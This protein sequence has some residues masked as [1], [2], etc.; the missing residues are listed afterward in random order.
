MVAAV[1]CLG[2]SFVGFFFSLPG[3]G[4]RRVFSAIYS[5]G[6]LLLLHVSED[7][8]AQTGWARDLLL[9]A[10]PLAVVF[11]G[12]T[13]WAIIME[14]S[15]NE[16][17]R[18][19]A[20]LRGKHT[21]ICGLG[22]A[23]QHLVR[24]FRRVGENVVVIDPAQDDAIAASVRRCGVALIRGSATDPRLLD[25]ARIRTADYLFAASEDDGTNIGVALRVIDA[26]QRKPGKRD[27]RLNA[28][29]HIADPQLRASLR[30]Q[31]AFR[32]A[33]NKLRINMFNVFDTMARSLLSLHPLDYKSI[34]PNDEWTVQIVIVGFGLM[35]E[36]ILA[37]AAMVGHYA[38]LRRLKAVV[39]DQN[40]NRKR[41]MFRVRYPQFDQVADVEFLESDVE[42]PETLDRI[43]ALCADPKTISTVLITF[44]QATRGLSV[45]ASLADKLRG[46]VPIRLRVSDKSGLFALAGTD[47]AAAILPRNVTVFGSVDEACRKEN[48]GGG[49]LDK[50]ARAM[51]ADYV[52]RQLKTN[53][54]QAKEGS[55]SDWDELADDLIDS[56][57]QQADHI[58][59][60]LRAVG[61]HVA[62]KGAPGELGPPVETFRDDEVDLLAKLE[63]RR[64]MAE[65]FMA[66]WVLGPRDTANRVSPYLVEWDLV[67]LNIQKYDRDFAEIL[68]GVLKLVNSEIRR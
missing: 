44:D 34:L 19:L 66:S 55:L 24:E 8:Q 22:G 68:P 9:I 4:W 2:L 21:V 47:A 53:P 40:A 36:A 11:V 57:R 46:E 56:N 33:G 3:A 65:R 14:F 38:N 64:W 7:G 20:A 35:G 16:I 28:F 41:M 51:H 13:T 39:I 63:H 6:A 18:I 43:A 1:A 60:K 62:A 49:D 30:R 50:I 54:D 23:S 25:R 52:A 42:E 17:R 32:P 5:S 31:N 10:R 37:R 59:V 27:S 67:P 48:F 29:V 12:A 58:A 61:C 45:A 26:I 15:G